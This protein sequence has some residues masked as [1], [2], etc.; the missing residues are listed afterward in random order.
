MS[1]KLA[2]PKKMPT[3]NLHYVVSM[4]R[5]VIG[6]NNDNTA[7]MQEYVNDDNPIAEGVYSVV[8]KG[9]Y[10]LMTRNLDLWKVPI[11]EFETVC[12][13]YA[14][15]HYAS[16]IPAKCRYKRDTLVDKCENYTAFSYEEIDYTYFVV[17][18]THSVLELFTNSELE[19]WIH[20]CHYTDF[21]FHDMLKEA[22]QERVACWDTE[23]Y[24]ELEPNGW[25]GLAS[26]QGRMRLLQIYQ[27][28]KKQCYIFD[29]GGRNNPASE[30]ERFAAGKILQD[31]TIGHT[32]LFQN[33]LFDLGYL[34]HQL[35]FAPW[36]INPKDTQLMSQ[37]LYAGIKLMKHS[38]AAIC[39][40]EDVDTD[41]DKTLQKS[42]FG[43]PL[44][45]AQLNYGA[46]DTR[47]TY[48]AGVKM[49]GKLRELGQNHIPMNLDCQYLLIAHMIRHYGMGIDLVSFEEIYNAT[50]E[51]YQSQLEIWQEESGVSS[52]SHCKAMGEWLESK[53][54]DGKKQDKATL[55]NYKEVLPEIQYLLNAKAAKKRLDYLDGVKSSMYYRETANTSALPDYPAITPGIRVLATQGMG[56][57]SQGDIVR[58]KNLGINLSNPGKEM[59]EFPDLPDY[60]PIF[61]YVKGFKTIGIDLSSA[62]LRLAIHLSNCINAK[63]GLREGEDIHSFNA[64]SMAKVC[65]DKDSP[66]YN[67]L[68][69]Y[70]SLL[71][72]R[73]ID[74]DE[75]DE[76]P[77]D[78]ETYI[79]GI[80]DRYNLEY[81]IEEFLRKLQK[82]AKYYRNIAK[83]AIYLAINFGSAYR[84][85]QSLADYGVYIEF[86]ECKVLMDVLWANI[87]EIRNYVKKMSKQA[88]Q[89]LYE[90]EDF[91]LDAPKGSDDEGI[92]EVKKGGNRP[93]DYAFLSWGVERRSRYVPRFEND[94]KY[95][96]YTSTN[97]CD[98]SAHLW[99]STEADMIKKA[100][101]RFFYEYILANNLF[102]KV[103]IANNCHDEV[104]VIA[105]ESIAI[106]ACETLITIMEEEWDKVCP[107][108]LGIEATPDTAIGS[109]W[110]D[111]K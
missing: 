47:Y 57:I 99:Q 38:L 85:Q 81:T 97:I 103:W 45:N 29:F 34:H 60:R 48:Y 43:L 37:N 84:L 49:M 92:E 30:E 53:G 25:K 13:Q 98:V 88:S 6:I 11:L 94:G 78:I 41:I 21:D 16:I 106:E 91:I 42:D 33:A 63:N 10:A 59:K 73:M 56:R 65:E 17:P 100:Q 31:N 28:K 77:E 20:Y 96:P 52:I 4:E 108:I 74:L 55:G 22:L 70:S 90:I 32:I 51:Y 95:G 23:T 3:G 80:V 87:P 27:P 9:V 101:I 83:T 39:Y 62:H 2:L 15:E 44:V 109:N 67:V 7:F 61:G 111:V 69:T 46:W 93:V 75:G 71:K 89:D 26:Y 5:W 66:H 105:H 110:G 64:A 36:W 102:G 68:K 58:P 8:K 72:I 107:G 50:K 35:N 104:V 76:I 54:Y 79:E 1:D 14:T 40:R 86:M 18:P 82:N 12:K 24:D 19:D